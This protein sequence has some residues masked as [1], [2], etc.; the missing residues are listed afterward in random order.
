M[1]DGVVQLA[2]DGAGK[3]VDTSELVVSA[4]T[5]ER[6]RVV[7]GD[8]SAAAGLAKVQNAAPGSTDYGLTVRQAGVSANN[9]E[10]PTT[11]QATFNG[12]GSSTTFALT[13]NM[14]SVSVSF[15]GNYSATPAFLISFDA[16]NPS[17]WVDAFAYWRDSNSASTN[18]VGYDLAHFC[19]LTNGTT[20]GVAYAEIPIPSGATFLKVYQ[21]SFTSGVATVKI[22]PTTM[23][24]QMPM[25]QMVTGALANN[26]Q[27]MAF[28]SVRPVIVGG[29][30]G[31]GNTAV[32]PFT[33]DSN[34]R[35]YA[36]GPAA[37][38][39][40]LVGNPL[41][42]GGSD[43][44]NIRDL[45]VDST[46]KLQM[47]LTAGTTLAGDT[48]VQYRANATG[49]ASNKHLISAA[50][51]NSTVVKASPGRLVGWSIANT[52]AA[53]RYV[54][55]HNATSAPTA[56]AGVVMTLAI[57]PNFVA[58][59][60]LDGGVAFTTGIGL[61]ATTGSADADTAAVGAGDLIIELFYA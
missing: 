18:N 1:S 59:M 20:G 49:A 4:Q 39:A 61:T 23:Q 5:V 13:S 26:T 38:G 53:F 46:G 32:V 29:L 56:G 51:T 58:Q 27:S 47:A 52:N 30:Q 50:T 8:D 24:S 6:Q 55:L 43:G 54:K 60:A 31:T 11:T 17:N 25:A 28:A 19:G 44:T 40:A 10:S 7:L 57:P 48:G 45:S 3:K 41:R 35:Q 2:P 15:T 14:K 12:S 42:I 37:N 22:T 16:S 33:A 9:A 34:G 36:V 21:S